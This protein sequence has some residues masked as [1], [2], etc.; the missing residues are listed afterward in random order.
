MKA[1]ET[2]K[3]VI[4]N[5]IGKDYVNI[6]SSLEKLGVEVIIETTPSSNKEN[7]IVSQSVSPG[8]YYAS[9]LR[10]KLQFSITLKIPEVLYPDFTN[11]NYTINDV[12]NFANNNSLSLTIIKEQSELPSGTI[13]SQSKETGTKVTTGATLKITVAE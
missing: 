8:K 3:I 1:Q 5:Y 11:G 7:T 6:K 2:L 12:M 10:G 13:I 4:D 9:V